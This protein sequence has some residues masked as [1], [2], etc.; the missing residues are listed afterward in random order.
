MKTLRG[1]NVGDEIV[2][3]DTYKKTSRPGIV[4]KVGT[5]LL[6]VGE[7]WEETV[8]YLD[9]GH[10]KNGYGDRR[11]MT[12]DQHLSW[13]MAQLAKERLCRFG[14]VPASRLSDD[15]LLKINDALLASGVP[16]YATPADEKDKKE[17][18]GGDAEKEGDR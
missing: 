1:V 11:A 2:I 13:Q 16:G 14:L 9:G 18:R 5:K 8:W 6:Y 4:S 17:V 7:G 3:V 15:A 10:E 12:H